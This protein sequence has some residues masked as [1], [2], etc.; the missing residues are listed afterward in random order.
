MNQTMTRRDMLK[1]VGLSVAGIAAAPLFSVR[2]QDKAGGYKLPPL[3]YACDALEP[4]I[5]ARTIAFHHDKHHQ[6]YVTNLN[7]ALEGHPEIASKPIEEVIKNINDV[8]ETIRIAVRN[9]GGGHA[10]HSLYWLF[11]NPDGGGEPKGA[12]AQAI[13]KKFGNFAAFKAQFSDAAMKRFGSGWAWLVRDK[14]GEL[15]VISTANQDSPL[16]EGQTPLL[17][18]DVWEHAYYLQYQNKRAD[19]VAAWWNVV[20]WKAVDGFFSA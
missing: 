10:N 13:N 18:V 9:N 16:S 11:M 4:H 2:A 3:P 17:V 12:V 8:P 6:T 7:K 20:N 5:D 19:Y 1:T 14:A 15:Q